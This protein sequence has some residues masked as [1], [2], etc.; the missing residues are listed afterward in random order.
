MVIYNLKELKEHTP[1]IAI[2]IPLQL[3]NK[4]AKKNL[5]TLRTPIQNAQTILLKNLQKILQK[6]NLNSTI[7]PQFHQMINTTCKIINLNNLQLRLRRISELIQAQATTIHN[8]ALHTMTPSMQTPT[9]SRMFMSRVSNSQYPVV[10]A[11]GLSLILP[12]LQ[13]QTFPLNSNLQNSIIS[14]AQSSNQ[15]SIFQRWGERSV[16]IGIERCSKWEKVGSSDSRRKWLSRG[17]SWWMIW[18]K[19]W[20]RRWD[21]RFIS[22]VKREKT[23]LR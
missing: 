14:I 17:I 13:M 8:L 6:K 23:N 22:R 9:T 11:R 18:I 19:G 4:I 10:R 1:S 7:I 20:L 3:T 5:G 2:E 21:S 16:G 12:P 15:T